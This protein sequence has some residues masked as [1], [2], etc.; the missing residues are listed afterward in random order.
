MITR[1]MS[2]ITGR[3]NGEIIGWAFVLVVVLVLVLEKFRIEDEDD[4]D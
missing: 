3:E 4:D 2:I 1:F